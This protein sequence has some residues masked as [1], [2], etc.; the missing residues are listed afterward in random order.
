M[1]DVFVP[2]APMDSAAA[3]RL[4]TTHSSENM[5]DNAATSC[6]FMTCWRFS[7][8]ATM[9]S[10]V[11]SPSHEDDDSEK[12]PPGGCKRSGVGQQLVW[13]HAAVLNK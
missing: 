10:R 5:S 4:S 12:R 9:S 11:I 2:A 1:P 7:N 13:T 3:V 6:W 8:K